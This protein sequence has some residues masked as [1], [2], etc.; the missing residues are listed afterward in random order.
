MS[1]HRNKNSLSSFVSRRWFGMV[2]FLQI[3]LGV[4]IG[5]SICGC[6][7]LRLGEGG[8]P[9]PPKE[10][11]F[12]VD[13][14][15]LISSGIRRGDDFRTFKQGLYTI[16]SESRLLLRYEML[17]E[18]NWGLRDDMPVRLRVFVDSEIDQQ[19][20]RTHLRVCPVTKNWMMAATWQAAHPWRGGEWAPGGDIDWSE[21]VSPEAV[22]SSPSALCSENQALCFDVSRWY[23]IWVLER[24]ENLG[25]VMLSDE[26]VKILGDGSPGKAP[27]MQWHETTGKLVPLAVDFKT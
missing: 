16:D 23:R 11:A 26:P 22:G 4:G 14:L 10:V 21:C 24:Q 27:R 7:E 8:E 15:K 1:I 19:T 6:G 13:A 2:M 17:L 9:V 3:T 12:A 5:L 18:K 20:A 25:L